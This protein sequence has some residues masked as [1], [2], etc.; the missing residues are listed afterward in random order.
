MKTTALRLG[1]FAT[2]LT[3]GAIGLAAC[4]PADS[5][6][7]TGSASGEKVTL[8]FANAD[9]AETW[10]LVIDAFEKSHPD[11]TVKQLNIPYAQY[12]STINQRMTGGGGDIDLMVV[13][14]GGAVLDWAN[15]GFLADIS[16]LKDDAVAAAVSEDMVTA[17][18]ADGKLYA[19]ETWTT[20]QFL[21]YNP[22]ILAAAGVEP[23]SD[24][25]AEPW[26]YE[27]LTAAA[28]KIKDAGAAEYPF[29]FDQWDSY[30]QLQMV[31]VSAGGGDGI[32]AD[33]DVDFS[34]DGWQKALTWYHDLFEDGLSPRGITNDKN[35][36]L[37][38][39]GKA[40]FIISGPWGVNVAEAG[41]IS[42][43]VAPAPF[44][45]GGEQ[46]TSTDSW[47]VAISAKTAKEDAAREFLEY[48]TIDPKGNAESAEV[49]GIA[50]TNKEAYATYADDMSAVGGDATANFGAIM[51]YQLENNAV[52]RP[53]VLG[54]SV[55]EPG[56]NQMFSDI[57]NGS[58]PAERAAQ[59]DKDIEAQIA[60][61]Q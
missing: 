49:A 50:P 59:A 18:E 52:H 24:D 38:Q 31:G 14:A 41:D 53:G 8:T 60:R 12:T 21:Y 28:Q 61:L 22:D 6:S 40:G 44:F 43:G 30:Y 37:F 56:A 17:R 10:A 7:D 36:A 20:S 45:E 39:T 54:Y 27:E 35:G 16:D 5:G 46:A 23:P 51:Q 4:A 42:Y 57:R 32:D 19:L 13:D 47:S 15:R 33:G 11:I 48:L 25:P 3:V 2:A 58:D 29:L 26:T 34:N 55:F 1:A 9:P